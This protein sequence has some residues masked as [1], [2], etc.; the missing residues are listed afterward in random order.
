MH[1]DS[2]QLQLYAETH[3]E[4]AFAQLVQRH[5]P[6]VYS[7]ALRQTGDPHHAEEVAQTVFLT[8][9]RKAGTLRDHPALGGWLYTTTCYT[10]AKARR[11][12]QRRRRR[13]QEA[14]TMQDPEDTPPPSADWVQL[15]PVLDETML[16]LK[17]DDRTAVLL[18]F[19]ENRPYGEIGARLG[20]NENTARMRVDRALE[21]LRT[22][23]ARRGIVSTAAA[24]G[25]LL[26]AQT[27]L[28]PPAGLAVAISVGAGSAAT[29]GVLLFLMKPT[30]LKT[31]LLTTVLCAGGAGLLWQHRENTRLRD[32]IR[33]LQSQ[34]TA[35]APSTTA[36][37]ASTPRHAGDELNRLRAQI[38]ELSRNPATSWQNRADQL[39]QLLAQLPEMNIPEI[40]ALATE[41]DWL[42]AAKNEMTTEGDYRRALSRLR[43]LAVQRFIPFASQAL[44]QYLDSHGGAFPTDPAQLQPYLKQPLNPAIWQRYDV[45]PASNV[46]NLG[47]G[48]DW[49]I[50]TRQFVDE[51]FDMKFVIGPNGSGA[52]SAFSPRQDASFVAVLKAYTAANSGQDLDDFNKLLPYAT[53]PEQRQAVQKAIDWT[54]NRADGF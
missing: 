20:L 11:T 49:I 37:P 15:R 12:E 2:E 28:T 39:R 48:G 31:G 54:R 23:L 8:L 46:P 24:L 44:K 19:F 29:G 34:T 16:L 30:L 4:P 5:L 25:T 41:E 51:D 14:Q 52:T 1:E 10:A 50:T 38:A 53:T 13:E 26:S 40:A 7:A 27:A 3:S 18:R 45:Q 9:A 6:L 36:G 22:A 21:A 42:E 33:Q 32:E 17:E 47:M 43:T 35:T